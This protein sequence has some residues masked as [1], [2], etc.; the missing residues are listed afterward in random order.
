MT[1][2]PDDGEREPMWRSRARA[3]RAR[4]LSG[5][6][7]RDIRQNLFFAF[8]Y[9]VAGVPFAAGILYPWFGLLLSPVIASAGHGVQLR[10]SD[11]KRLEATA[12][13][14]L[15]DMYTG[16]VV[17]FRCFA[18]VL[19]VL[20]AATPV[21]AVVCAMD[22]DQ[23]PSTPAC[24]TSVASLDGPSL[25][26]T[27]HLCDHDH[28]AGSPALL[29]GSSARGFAETFVALPV[30]TLAH[31]SLSDARL[32]IASMH[33]PPGLSARSTSSRLTVLRI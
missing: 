31:L 3:V 32:A 20:L 16:S 6:M 27:G 13:R 19:A 2:S 12:R 8:I 24:H 14:T 1:M 5:A 15:E 21:L 9:N 4:R 22:C 28:T 26:S 11:R 33:G 25:R 30:P 7:M 29:V 10:V 17:R 23:P 18:L